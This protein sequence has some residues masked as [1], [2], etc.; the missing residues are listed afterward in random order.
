MNGEGTSVNIQLDLCAKIEI[1]VLLLNFCRTDTCVAPNENHPNLTG[2]K[3][4]LEK[5]DETK[6]EHNST[7][8]EF[9]VAAAEL[10]Q[11]LECRLGSAWFIHVRV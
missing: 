10:N 8:S 4:Y 6:I 5:K 9:S 11:F 1:I 3:P 2:P 7:N